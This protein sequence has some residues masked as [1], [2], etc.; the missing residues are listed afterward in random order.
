MLKSEDS[1]LKCTPLRREEICRAERLPGRGRAEQPGVVAALFHLLFSTYSKK[2]WIVGVNLLL[3]WKQMQ[4][5]R[6]GLK[7]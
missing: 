2:M 5:P 4:A 3:D 6:S 1:V 7:P